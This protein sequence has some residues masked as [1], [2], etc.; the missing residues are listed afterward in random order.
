VIINLIV[1]GNMLNNQI[2]KV[3]CTECIKYNFPINRNLEESDFNHYKLCYVING[4]MIYEDSTVKC[5]MQP[6]YFYILPDRTN[7]SLTYPSID[8]VVNTEMLI[9]NL[10]SQ[11]NLCNTIIGYSTK[12]FEI[13]NYYV[14]YITD[15]IESCCY[16]QG[17]KKYETLLNMSVNV[18]FNLLH[19]LKPFTIH[20]D[21]NINRAIEYIH[22]NINKDLS[23]ETLAKE[24]MLSKSYFIKSFTLQLKDTPQQYILKI[25][26]STAKALLKEKYKLEKICEIIG[27]ESISA[28]CR[29]F[30][31]T[32]GTTPTDFLKQ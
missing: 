15:I 24:A 13:L 17:E 25:K 7:Y 22:N 12:E 26:M 14:P 19:I 20:Y 4:K 3:E 31:N 6:N 9:C 1:E 16:K 10:I 11:P 23:N 18:L 32:F 5:I 29:A 21:Q 30:K 2:I 28:F 8:N 27:Y